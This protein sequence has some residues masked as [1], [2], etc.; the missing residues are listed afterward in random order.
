MFENY[1]LNTKFNFIFIPIKLQ[2]K[3]KLRDTY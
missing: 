1:E 3:Q 2:S